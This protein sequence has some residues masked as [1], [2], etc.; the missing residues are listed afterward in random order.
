MFGR[1]DGKTIVKGN[2]K[3]EARNTGLLSSF[4]SKTTI[5]DILKE[6]IISCVVLSIF[7]SHENHSD[8]RIARKRKDGS[9]ARAVTQ[10]MM[11][12]YHPCRQIQ[13]RISP[14][15]H[16]CAS[17]CCVDLRPRAD[18]SEDRRTSE[19][20]DAA[21]YRGR[22]FQ[23]SEFHPDDHEILLAQPDKHLVDTAQK[24]VPTDPQ[25]G[26]DERQADKEFEGTAGS[27]AGKNGKDHHPRRDHNHE[28]TQHREHGLRDHPA[29][30]EVKKTYPLIALCNVFH[31]VGNVIL[32]VAKQ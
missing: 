29:S 15:K 30:V 11:R 1:K 23:G 8:Q 31:K 20:Q 24:G 7:F 22:D 10:V 17:G 5:L 2:N 16:H 4:P 21:A 25:D 19:K 12:G 18:N 28:Q 9:G 3:K 6:I 14:P 27:Y 26:K 13:S 32:F